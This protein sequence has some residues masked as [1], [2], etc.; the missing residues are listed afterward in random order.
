MNFVPSKSL[1]E[2][3]TPVYKSYLIFML[4]S[5]L[6][7]LNQIIEET[8]HPIIDVTA[9]VIIFCLVIYSV[10][11]MKKKFIVMLNRWMRTSY[12]TTQIV[13]GTLGVFLFVE[14]Y[15]YLFALM[16]GQ[17]TQ[18]IDS[19]EPVPLF[20][21]YFSILLYAPVVEEIYFRGFVTRKLSIILKPKEVVVLQGFL[22]GII[23]LNPITFIS[24]SLL[25]IWLGHVKMK[26]GSILPGI[27]IHFIWN[28]WTLTQSH[29]DFVQ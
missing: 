2:E 23:H 1:L 21:D 16:G 28:F 14:V 6:Y 5:L 15:F 27:A 20:L 10:F 18:L 4:V 12:S 25:G 26:T 11:P 22:F 13:F 17:I 19:N 9:M 3:L 29:Y 8:Y 24:H 7:L